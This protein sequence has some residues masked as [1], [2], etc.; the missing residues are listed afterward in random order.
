M[1]ILIEI[2][3]EEVD[4][5]SYTHRTNHALAQLLA[6]AHNFGLRG[7]HVYTYPECDFG[8]IPASKTVVRV[9]KTED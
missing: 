1:K 9:T 6:A 8:R 7:E 5:P 3:L 2:E 4:M